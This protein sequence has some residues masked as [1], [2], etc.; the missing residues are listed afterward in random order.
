MTPPAIIDGPARTPRQ[1]GLF[2]VA[3]PVTGEGRWENGGQWQATLTCPG[4]LGAVGVSCSGT[5][6]AP[7]IVAV[8][9]ATGPA[10]G[11]TDIVITGSGFLALLDPQG[12]AKDLAD[13]G[14]SWGEADAFTVYASHACGPVG[15]DDETAA[16]LAMAELQ[17]REEARVEEI[18]ATGELGNEPNFLGA[19]TPAGTAALAPVV[20]LALLEQAMGDAYGGNGVIHASRA[21]AT[22]LAPYLT[23]SG[24]QLQTMLGT[25]VAAGAGYPV[26]GPDGLPLE[27]GAW[28]YATP[29]V[30]VRRTEVFTSTGRDLANNGRVI[31]AERTYLVGWDPCPVLAV[32]VSLTCC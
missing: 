10:D 9:P 24:T 7:D 3:P 30:A 21:A 23:R 31:L 25:P 15:T 16:Q 12:P 32:P 28:L 5:P 13:P 19:E 17:A 14:Q 4:E 18:V 6:V 22:V 1:F 8:T 27:D 20:A 29:P 11:G 2:S 26:T